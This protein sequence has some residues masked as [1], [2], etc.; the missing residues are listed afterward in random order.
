MLIL[1]QGGRKYPEW[2]EARCATGLRI[3]QHCISQLERQLGEAGE[4]W[5]LCPLS[6]F[7]RAKNFSG[8]FLNRKDFLAAARKIPYLSTCSEIPV[9]LFILARVQFLFDA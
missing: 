6:P 8:L 4:G 2:M 3:S 5:A 7:L 1:V 9:A